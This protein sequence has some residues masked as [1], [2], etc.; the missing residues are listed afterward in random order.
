MGPEVAIAAIAAAAAV[1]GAVSSTTQMV[2]GSSGVNVSDTKIH[3]PKEFST[4]QFAKP[5]QSVEWD[6]MKFKAV[7]TLWDN[8]CIVSAT[9]Y[10]SNDSGPLLGYPESGSPH[11]PCNRFVLLEFSKSSHSQDMSQGL[12]NVN[13]DA[14]GGDGVVAEGTAEDPWVAL[15]VHGRFDPVGPGDVEYSYKLMVNTFGH[16]KMSDASVTGWGEAA[17]SFQGDHVLLHLEQHE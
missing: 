3:F 11:V 8:L 10:V 16:I 12:L 13:I 15:K 7:G 4:T 2:S 9:G 17:I 6:I 14:W 5:G 1:P